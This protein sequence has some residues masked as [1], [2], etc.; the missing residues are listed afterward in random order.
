VTPELKQRLVGAAVLLFLAGLLWM[1]LFDFEASEREVSPFVAIPPM[2]TI[3][4]LVIEPATPFYNDK[5]INS[6][7]NSSVEADGVS[8]QA[9]SSELN[10][11]LGD[12][13]DPKPIANKTH[14]VDPASRPRLDK[15]GVPVAYV[16]QLGSFK[17]FDN[18]NK[19]RD[20]LVNDYQFKA[21]VEPRVEMGEGPYKVLVGPVLTYAD[22]KSLAVELKNNAEIT[23]TMIKRFGDT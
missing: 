14:Y 2:P 23:S 20:K 5:A 18:A 16:I 19:L 10:K 6:A 4:S 7:S 17:Q 21:F 9:S 12:S 13:P 15:Q 3:E 8:E 11:L 1:L 22:A